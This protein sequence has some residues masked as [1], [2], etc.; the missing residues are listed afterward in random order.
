MKIIDTDDAD[1]REVILTD[2][3][4]SEE[5]DADSLDFVLIM[6]MDRGDNPTVSIMLYTDEIQEYVEFDDCLPCEAIP[7]AAI[8]SEIVLQLM[9]QFSANNVLEQ[10]LANLAA[11]AAKL[12]VI[13]TPKDIRFVLVIGNFQTETTVDAALLKRFFVSTKAEDAEEVAFI[14]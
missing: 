10:I 13:A 11:P 5:A 7:P 9:D 4:L 6:R 3:K 14:D 8:S 2:V 1:I 12:E